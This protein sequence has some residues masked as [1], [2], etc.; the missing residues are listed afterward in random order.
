MSQRQR[1]TQE[2]KALQYPVMQGCWVN[3]FCNAQSF[4]INHGLVFSMG[5]T[6]VWIGVDMSEIS[7]F[8]VFITPHLEFSN[9]M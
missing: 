6:T 3:H 5:G 4:L 9:Q 2:H 8:F 1:G 7:I